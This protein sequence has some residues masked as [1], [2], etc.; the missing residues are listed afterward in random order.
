MLNLLYFFLVTTAL[1]FSFHD[2]LCPD[3]VYLWI[4]IQSIAL[5]VSSRKNSKNLPCG[6]FFFVRFWQNVYCT[7]LIP[8]N[9]LCPE[10]F[11]IARP[12]IF[13]CLELRKYLKELLKYLKLKTLLLLVQPKLL[14]AAWL[15]RRTKMSDQKCYH[16]VHI[17]GSAKK[18]RSIFSPKVPKVDCFCKIYF[19]RIC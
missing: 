18:L 10:K 4:E 13:W 19:N 5:R 2:F 7:A 3:C 11:L 16:Q 9:L 8:Q 12:L 6:T 15:G 17:K 1:L 14:T